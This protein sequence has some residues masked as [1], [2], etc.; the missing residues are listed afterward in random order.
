MAR[1]LLF[2]WLKG[3]KQQQLYADKIVFP[4]ALLEVKVPLRLAT[5]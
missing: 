2:V 1:D 4:E 5:A 3:A